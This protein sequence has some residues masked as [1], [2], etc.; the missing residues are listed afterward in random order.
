MLSHT[1]L[2]QHL[3]DVPPDL[4]QPPTAPSAPPVRVDNS[5]DMVRFTHGLMAPKPKYKVFTNGLME[6]LTVL[7]IMG[8][9]GLI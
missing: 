9:G 8:A 2:P 1:E 6:N 4:L 7:G 3:D 5:T